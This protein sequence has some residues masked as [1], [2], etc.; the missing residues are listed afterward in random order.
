MIPWK[1]FALAWLLLFALSAAW[2]LATPIGGGPDEPAHVIKAASVVRGQ[3]IGTPSELGQVVQVPAYLAY[4][5][6]QTC[7][8]FYPDISA[9]CS[10]A[11]GTAPGAIVDGTTT[12]GLYNPVYYALVGA[13]TL[14]AQDQS[15]IYLVR[16]A[17][18]ALSCLFLAAAFALLTTW[19]R[20]GVAL[21]AFSV[22]VTPMVLFV[23]GVVNPN[24]L[25]IAAVLATFVGMLSIIA[26]P[27]SDLLTSRAVVVL[28]SVSIAVNTRGLAPVW[29]A[30]AILVPLILARRST[31]TAL[32][33]RTSVRVAVLG[34]GISTALAVAWS[35]GS[36]SLTAG[37]VP[38]GDIV[39]PT[40][41]GV[42]AADGIIATLER[43]FLLGQSMIGVFGWLDT[44]SPLVV[45]FVW[46]VF[47][48]LLTAPAVILL[49]GRQLV[50]A[51]A[52]MAGVVVL[53]ALIQGAYIT[54]GGYIWQGR[55]TLPAFVCLVVGLG[56]V[57]ATR[58][59]AVPPR[60]MVRLS[61][62]VL[63]L[64]CGGQSYAFVSA[65]KRYA[66]GADGTWAGMVRSAE[67]VPP[68]GILL[69]P[70]LFLAVSA[71][72]AVLLQ[73]MVTTLRVPV[74]DPPSTTMQLRNTPPVVTLTHPAPNAEP[75]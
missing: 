35:L 48:G 12:A 10:A 68:G 32:L 42:S 53:P 60:V 65:L 18:A 20:R 69:W 11:L 45:F 57:L 39:S 73:R 46:T 52:L 74:T 34:V 37:L 64:W 38:S 8:A 9:S 29:V 70:V 63:V 75:V 1:P 61:T 26:H 13:P 41:D 71:S 67:W 17:S 16:L 25:E 43:T 49:H 24:S 3:L 66:V 62:V 51:V 59:P 33:R 6:Q 22:A 5:H 31:L 44:F 14:F 47:I 27:R 23:N 30:V 2:A 56:A 7:F 50:F 40:G 72:A 28:V 55:Y 15:G 19:R 4:T 54:G 36:S 21:L 58:A